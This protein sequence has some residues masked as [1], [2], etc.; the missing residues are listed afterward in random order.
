MFASQIEKLNLQLTESLPEA[1]K[2]SSASDNDM[3][4]EIIQ[5]KDEIFH[6]KRQVAL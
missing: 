5:L 2:I 3:R 1:S 4:T 6:L